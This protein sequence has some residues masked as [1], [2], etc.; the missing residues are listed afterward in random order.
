M[1]PQASPRALRAFVEVV[2][3]R[4]IAP[5]ARVLGVSPSA[6]SHLLREL[7]AGLGTSL[8]RPGSRRGALTEAGER[9]FAG[10]GDAFDRIDRAVAELGRRGGEVRV[11]TLSSFATLWLV[12]RLPRLQAALPGL[13]VLIATETR[14]VDLA[15]E[16]FDCAI[17]WGMGDWPGL[18]VAKL[19]PEVLVAVA[20]P[21]LLA[22]REGAPDLAALPRIAARSRPEDWPLLLAAMGRREEAAPGLVFETRA[23]AVRA[24]IAG[25][26]AAVVDRGLV[27]DAL[28]AGHLVQV[29]P[30]TVAR[31]EAHFFVARPEALREKAVRGF[32]D[33]L[34][35]E[36]G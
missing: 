30:V 9:L 11:S 21:G 19:V 4:G 25:L 29:S 13:R 6:V 32:R 12:P 5:A 18:S 24:A 8:F 10:I 28:A 20:G 34:V 1:F 3:R 14:V 7:E 22:G 16:P 35:A 17:R 31:P 36:A 33:W 26:G 2:R 23:L 27:A 15:A